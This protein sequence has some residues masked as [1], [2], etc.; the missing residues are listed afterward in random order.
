MV[1]RLHRLRV[2]RWAPQRIPRGTLVGTVC[3]GRIRSG[4]AHCPVAA[5]RL[6]GRHCCR[7]SSRS[8]GSTSRMASDGR[9][10]P[11]QDRRR[12]LAGGGQGR[13]AAAPSRN[14]VPRIQ[15]A[16]RPGVVQPIRA[17]PGRLRA[18]QGG[19][20]CWLG[21]RSPVV[22]RDFWGFSDAGSFPGRWPAPASVLHRCIIQLTVAGATASTWWYRRSR[23][24]TPVPHARPD[25]ERPWIRSLGRIDCGIGVRDEGYRVA[26]RPGDRHDACRPRWQDNRAS[27]RHRVDC[28]DGSR[29]D[30]DR[31]S[32]RGLAWIT[33]RKCG[34]LPVGADAPANYCG[35]SSARASASRGGGTRTLGCNRV[36]GRSDNRRRDMAGA[37]APR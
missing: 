26:C 36:P 15:P 30:S 31:A 22:V 11:A 10:S 35:E 8:G 2:A 34:G 32:R 27:V 25:Q 24:G 13:V 5:L 21:R 29:N 18:A 7:G 6:A 23:P 33:D 1:C 9:S 37:P 3:R 20:P 28:H 16:I 14:S 17:S 19:R 12:R 4:R